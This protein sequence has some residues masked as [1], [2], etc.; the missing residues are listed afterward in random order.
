MVR[1]TSAIVV[2]SFV[3]AALASPL[4]KRTVAQVESDISNIN[5]QVNSLN[6][7][8]EAFPDSGG[9]LSEALAIHTSAT[10]LE[11]AINSATSDTQAIYLHDLTL[12]S[13]SLI[14]VQATDPFS[15]ADGQTILSQVQALEPNITSALQNI[16][17][18]KPAFEAL[19]I[20]GIPALVEQDLQ[21]L[22][23]DT[24]AFANALIA[25]TPAD[26]LDQANSI[27]SDID[28]A[29]ATAVAAYAS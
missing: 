10:N 1:I 2:F 18:K 26:L 28:S 7:A 6:T 11:T 13:S 3:L 20:G 25:N 5:D 21:T 17:E 4:S 9:S 14:D 12:H 27:K 22:E 16:V 23:S 8:I 19:P 15:D 24:S 29:F